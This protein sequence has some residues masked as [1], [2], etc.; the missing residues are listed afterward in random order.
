MAVYTVLKD[1]VVY[2]TLVVPVYDV[3]VLKEV[4]VEVL[5]SVEI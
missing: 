4:F 1:V 3:D 5:D 2:V